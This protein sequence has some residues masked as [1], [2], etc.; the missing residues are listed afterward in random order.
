MTSEA[1]TL[2]PTE[3]GRLIKLLRESRCWSQEQ[4]A[5]IAK[6]SSRTVQRVED[7]QPSSFDTRRAL[8]AAY[9]CEDLDVFNKAH[10]IPTVEELERERKHFEQSHVSLEA[11][12]VISGKQLGK[13][14]E[15][16]SAFF[17]DENEL[18]HG[19]EEI[20]ARLA[21]YCR[22]YGD[23]HDLYTATDKLEIYA[24]LGLWLEELAELGYTLVCARR[25]IM[26][27]AGEGKAGREMSILYGIG[28]PKGQEPESLMVAREVSFR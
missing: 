20:F 11:A 1:R 27:G 28:F 19:A 5:D 24:E 13:W 25:R 4:L 8:A 26:L 21:D 6:L 12:T 2:T 15:A 22:E 10:V 23:C 14:V 7:G 9:G 18:R 17:F 16:S 3:L